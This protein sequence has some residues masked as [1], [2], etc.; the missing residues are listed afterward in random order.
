MLRSS[1]TAGRATLTATS[2]VRVAR[3]RRLHSGIATKIQRVKGGRT[4]TST[5]V[6][7]ATGA[8]LYATAQANVIHND[9]PTESPEAK[10]RAATSVLSNSPSEDGG[11]STIVWGSNK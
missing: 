9:A 10:A 3:A 2:P 5:A 4:L 6:A 7:I 11:L 1:A 8:I